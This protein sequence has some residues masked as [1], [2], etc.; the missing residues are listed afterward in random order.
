MGKLLAQQKIGLVY[1]G[2]KVG[3][4]GAVANAVLKNGGSVTGVIP[5]SL[6]SAEVAHHE[7]T[8]LHIVDDMHSRKKM[9]YDLSDAFLILPGGLGTLDEMFEILTWSQ[10]GLAL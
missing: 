9:M 7:I 8:Q 4:M 1:G 5:K 6:V 10:L 3:I 2:G